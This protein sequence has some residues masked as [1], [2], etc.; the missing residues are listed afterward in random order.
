M[1]KLVVLGAG[2]HSQ[3]NHLPALKRYVAEH[4]GEIELAAL[5][6]LR[7][8]HAEA[9]AVQYGF[10][11]VYTGPD[12]ML[13]AEQP[14]GCIAITPIPATAQV[15]STIIRAGVPLLMEKPPGATIEEARALVELV[16]KTGTPTMVSMNRR[17]DPALRAGLDWKGD[18]PITYLRGSIVRHN[19]REPEFILGTA[20][21]SLDAMRAMAHHSLAGDVLRF[22][23]ESHVV[24]GTRWYVVRLYFAGGALG[25]LEVLPAAGSVAESYEAFGAHWRIAVQVGEQDRGRARCWQDGQ[26]ALSIDPAQGQPPFVRNGTYAETAAFVE[27]IRDGKPPHPTPA[28]TLQSVELCHQI[29]AQFAEE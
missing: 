16:E 2:D 21:H 23:A 29:A 15:A 27:A 4:P 12:E 11:R 5:C 18:R 8:H 14:D 9:V 20:I 25:V 19:R 17:F 24:D 1:F 22:E 26:L 10:A 28:Q 3:H 13:R 6:D 7:R